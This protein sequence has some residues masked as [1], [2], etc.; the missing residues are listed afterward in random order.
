M[1]LSTTTKKLFISAQQILKLIFG[2]KFWIYCT[3]ITLHF[4]HMV[5]HVSAHSKVSQ[6]ITKY[7][8]EN[9]LMQGSMYL[10][11]EEA[12][13]EACYQSTECSVF[14]VSQSH[15]VVKTAKKLMLRNQTHVKVC[16]Y[17]NQKE[18]QVGQIVFLA[19]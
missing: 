11:H 5:S 16:L 19:A 1:V 8:H 17:L 14:N 15:N 10:Q 13:T 9:D 18:P 3:Y 2:T 4:T 12:C 6:R 7:R